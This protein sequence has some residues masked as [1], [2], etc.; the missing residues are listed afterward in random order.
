MADKTGELDDLVASAQRPAP[1]T[2]RLVVVRCGKGHSWPSFL[3]TRD[4][5]TVVAQ[6]RC[7]ECGGVYV[8]QLVGRTRV[9]IRIE[10]EIGRIGR[11]TLC[12][13]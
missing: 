8:D 1:P 3:T 2:H 11:W 9:T 7:V 12:L 6:T 13:S 5:A 10:S 4:G